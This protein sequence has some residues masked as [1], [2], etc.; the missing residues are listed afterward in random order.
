MRLFLS[1]FVCFFLFF[2]PGTL[3][4]RVDTAFVFPSPFPFPTLQEMCFACFDVL[5]AHFSGQSTGSP[6]YANYL[7]CARAS[8]PASPLKVICCRGKCGLT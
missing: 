1:I 2:L 3:C 7:W 4:S 5:L 6:S 8:V